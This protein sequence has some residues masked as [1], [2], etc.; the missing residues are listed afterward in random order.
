M[1]FQNGKKGEG[2]LK[3]TSELLSHLP[4]TACASCPSALWQV[5]G[6]TSKNKQCFCRIMFRVVWNVDIKDGDVVIDCMGLHEDQVEENVEEGD[7]EEE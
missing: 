2:T 5:V 4:E 1:E 3:P 6:K 7:E